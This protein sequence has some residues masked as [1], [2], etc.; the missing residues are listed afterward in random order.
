L[1]Q[2]AREEATAPVVPLRSTGGGSAT[3]R[4]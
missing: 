2:A 1:I 4:R 3:V